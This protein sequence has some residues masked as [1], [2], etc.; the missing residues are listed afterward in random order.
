MVND[1][2]LSRLRK[3]AA[4][5]LLTLV[6]L[7]DYLYCNSDQMHV[8]YAAESESYVH[9]LSVESEP[10]SITVTPGEKAV[11]T[12]KAQG[13]GKL[14]YQWYYKKFGASQWSLWRGHVTASTSATANATWNLMQVRCLITDE[15][16]AQVYSS[17]AL[18]TVKQ[19]LVITS[20]PVNLSVR[21]GEKVKFT[22]KASG[23]G[24][25]GY[26]W[27]Y[28]KSGASQWSIW[29]GHV[30][31][32]TWATV[33]STWNLMQVRCLITDESGVQVYSSAALITVSQ[34]LVITSQPSEV[35]VHSGDTAVFNVAAQGT[36]T[37]TYQ[38]YYRK[39]GSKEWSLWENKNAANISAKADC[40]WH[41]MQVFC[42]VKDATGS[43]V[44]SNVAEVSITKQSDKRYIHRTI[45]VK[46]DCKVY[47]APGTE[48]KV[49][50]KVVKG[51]KYDA[52]EWEND[53]K[54]I[55][56]FAFAY[57]GKT[58]WISRK[59][60]TVS[61][62]FT[63][64]PKRDFSGGGLPIIYLSPSR[65]IHNAY[66]GG[67]TNEQVQMYRVGTR[68]NKILENE[69]ICKVYMPPVSMEIS[70][71]KRPLDAY[72]KGADVYLAIHSNANPIGKSYGATG[73]YFPAC[74]Q[75]KLLSQN[76][77]REM[78]KIQ[79]KKS[80]VAQS[81]VAGM[82]AFDQIGYGEVRDPAYY[83]MISLLAEVEYHDHADTAKWI[84][85]NPDKIARALANAL[86]K[87]IGMQK[88]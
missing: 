42:Q 38:W 23:T 63:T 62:K 17:A 59:N 24:K 66:A 14:S 78:A 54:D 83:G 47:S 61:D 28:K 80:T 51:R 19:E 52:L 18:I 76:V 53:S 8:V 65:Q 16:G 21:T 79:Y 57:K 81:S 37:L 56:W 72:N 73:Y 36:G 11:F 67:S 87:T 33:N 48:N 12:V 10:V 45:T 55:T 69:Y 32:S 46:T 25:L 35:K 27:Y 60:A 88:K 71:K 74:A 41:C 82:D 68:L 49:L 15:S 84:I 9:A 70:L 4:A 64:V 39:Y 85:N 34:E 26:Q 13:T 1:M 31:A 30:T 22:V 3:T 5:F 40:T 20:Q 58:G 77:I 86:E 43:T 50:G 29:K 6:F 2:K 7:L 44:S 75:S